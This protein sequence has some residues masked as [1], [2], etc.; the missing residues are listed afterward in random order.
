MQHIDY[1][2]SSVR[3]AASEV[4]YKE[5]KNKFYRGMVP[6]L[7]GSCVYGLTF[8]TS[9][10]LLGVGGSLGVTGFDYFSIFASSCL[11]YLFAHPFYLAA[12]RV[13]YGTDIVP[14][15]Q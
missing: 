10:G 7:L 9:I 11:G 12:V 4:Y 14:K 15:E 1:P 8:G 13:R 5:G 3:E 6:Y 2:I